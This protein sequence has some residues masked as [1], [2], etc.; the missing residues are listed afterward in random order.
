MGA[1]M[2]RDVCSRPYRQQPHQAEL[3]SAA[4][5]HGCKQKWPI[6]ARHF[7]LRRARVRYVGHSRRPAL[8]LASIT[9]FLSNNRDEVVAA[10]VLDHGRASVL[11]HVGK[12]GLQKKVG[13]RK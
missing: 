11:R 9:T 10:S 5:R 1:T 6:A 13:L 2:D 12:V 3:L 4:A 8:A 7:Y